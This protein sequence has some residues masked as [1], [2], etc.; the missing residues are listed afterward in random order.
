MCIYYKKMLYLF[1]MFC[2]LNKSE[3]R[4]TEIE[5]PQKE[6]SKINDQE[7][8]KTTISSKKKLKKTKKT[9]SNIQR[10]CYDSD[11]KDYEIVEMKDYE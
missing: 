5:M 10:T 6:P 11:T 8:K 3:S 4:E 7:N 9:K 1:R 2:K